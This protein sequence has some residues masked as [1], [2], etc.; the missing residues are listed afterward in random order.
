MNKTLLLSA[1]VLLAQIALSQDIA[2]PVISIDFLDSAKIP[3]YRRARSGTRIVVEIR[4]LNRSLYKVNGAVTQREFNTE[5]PDIFSAIELPGYLTFELPG[6]S[7]GGE[8]SLLPTVDSLREAFEKNLT[9]IRSA[10]SLV[11]AAPDYNNLL[12]NAFRSCDTPYEMLEDRVVRGTADFL[13]RPFRHNRVEQAKQIQDRLTRAIEVAVTAGEDNQEIVYEYLKR[14]GNGKPDLVKEIQAA[15]KSSN[16]H[17]VGLKKFRDANRIQSL[18]DNY[19]MINPS[20][21]TFVTDTIVVSGDEI[22]VNVVIEAVRLLPCD[23]AGRMVIN[24]TYRTKGGWKVD[25]SPGLFLNSGSDDFMGFGYQYVAVS[26]TTTTIQRSDGGSSA[27]LSI[28]ALMHI[29]RRSG[30][31]LNFA[32]SPGLSITTAFDGLNFH[33]GASAIIGSRQRLVLTLGMTFREAEVLDKHYQLN[34]IYPE[35]ALPGN[36]P[37]VKVFPKSGWFA[38][39]TYN[40]S[41]L[42]KK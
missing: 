15:L 33:A 28:G 16:D 3:H 12:I 6:P 32:F 40:W 1:I 22:N 2:P 17:V 24:D 5:L 10:V 23:R 9:S 34:T 38:G 21:F 37:T 27:L 20:N 35:D 8:Q 29:Y 31:N 4:N 13:G 7:D 36:P 25:F 14:I 18:V 11:D 19:N 26:D 42:R 41:R 30:T 39:L